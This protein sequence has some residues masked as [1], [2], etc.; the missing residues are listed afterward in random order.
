MYRLNDALQDANNK[1]A[2]QSEAMLP[3]SL[4]F[5][6]YV[7]DCKIRIARCQNLNTHLV[8]EDTKSV[9]DLI[10]NSRLP[11]KKYDTPTIQEATEEDP[12]SSTADAVSHSEETGKNAQH[13]DDNLEAKTDE[14]DSSEEPEP[15]G[16]D[17]E[18][19]GTREDAQEGNDSEF[20]D[21]VEKWALQPM[22]CVF[23]SV[24]ESDR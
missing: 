12:E 23:M 22:L 4:T 14:N 19:D 16:D 15:Q 6:E 9:I 24:W 20:A 18:Q 21:A 2:E 10:Y 13:N 7:A 1:K 5:F 3:G 8:F 11:N 17:D